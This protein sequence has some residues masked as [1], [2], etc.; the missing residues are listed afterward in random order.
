VR[1]EGDCRFPIKGFSVELKRPGSN[2]AEVSG[3]AIWSRASAPPVFTVVVPPSEFYALEITTELALF[4]SSGTQAWTRDKVYATWQEN[5]LISTPT[6]TLPADAWNRLK[7]A[8]CLFYRIRSSTARDRWRNVRSI[9]PSSAA[10]SVPFIALVDTVGDLARPDRL[11]LYRLIIPPAGVPV[12][13]E[14]TIH[15][16]YSEQSAV[17]VKK[18]T[19]LPDGPTLD[20]EDVF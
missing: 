7:N 11:V 8:D 14:N 12:P 4:S 3:P 18:V 2:V 15:V 17:P 6:A 19:V 9:P 5:A 1:V 20:L 16:A 13:G 10:R